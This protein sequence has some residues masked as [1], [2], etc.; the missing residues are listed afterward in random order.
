MAPRTVG[1]AQAAAP[2]PIRGRAVS[3]TAASRT[4]RAIS[5]RRSAGT[6]RAWRSR[7]RPATP[8]RC[9]TPRQPRVRPVAPGRRRSREGIARRVADDGRQLGDKRRIAQTASGFAYATVMRGDYE[10]ALPINEEAVA[11]AGGRRTIHARG[12]R[13]DGRAD[14]PDAGNHGESRAAFHE[15]LEL[16]HEAGNI[17]GTCD[18]S[19]LSALV[20]AGSV[21]V[22][23]PVAALELHA[24]GVT[25]GLHRCPD[26]G[27]IPS[28]RLARRCRRKSSI[29]RWR[30][31]AGWTWTPPSLC[32]R[33]RCAP[34]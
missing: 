21:R 34:P 27:R 22:F 29:A 16:K 10:A 18:A 28:G 19:M 14:P 5:T 6:W 33:D 20:G 4:G 26:D 31:A 32:P 30:R 25:R 23:P 7:A 15:A 2:T 13:R 8:W 3:R 17:R 11:L 9:S 12:R 1:D 24:G